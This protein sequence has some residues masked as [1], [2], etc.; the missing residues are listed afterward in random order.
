MKKPKKDFRL[1]LKKSLLNKLNM[2]MSKTEEQLEDDP[3]L[4]LGFGMNAYFDTLR[5]LVILMSLCF[6]FSLPMMYIFSS[7]GAIRGAP[8]GVIS[9]Y[10]LGN[11]GGA[12]TLCKSVPFSN[13]SITLTCPKGT[14]LSSKTI[15]DNEIGIISKNIAKNN[16]C[17]VDAFTDTAKCSTYLP[18]NIKSLFNTPCDGKSSCTVSVPAA[19]TSF[20]AGIPSD[21]LSPSSLFFIQVP[22]VLSAEKTNT[23][24]I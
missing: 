7:Y 15:N 6:L 21:C 4:L 22:C 1:A 17:Q 14:E 10:S 16:W 19:K 12:S 5:Y 13:P 8:R 20:K 11:M 24:Q 3:F 9:Q 2:K 23:R 18:S